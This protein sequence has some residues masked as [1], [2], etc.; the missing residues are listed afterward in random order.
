MNAN[1]VLILSP[2]TD[3]A[4][5]GCGGLISRL[6]SEKKE[7]FWVAFSTAR[8][9]LPDNMP[10]NTLYQEFENVTEFLGLRKDQ[11]R[12][13]DFTVRRLNEKRQEI[14]EE[15][16]RIRNVF[17]PDTVIG[18]SLNDFHQDHTIVA[19][20]MIRAFKSH[21][22]IISYELPWNHLK[23]ENQFFVRLS[24]EEMETKIHLLDFYK[25]QIRA[26][27]LYFSKDYMYG[28]ARTRGGQIGARY[29]EAFEVVR[30]IQ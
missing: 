23:F 14:L 21:C 3:D 22:S 6:V 18:P 24:E 17:N 27:R 9:S 1:R 26:N 19:N 10:D 28:L 7:I 8:E 30:L 4:E 25:S 20:E 11:Y 29:A 5:L 12:I 13:F 2:H 16:V 15:L